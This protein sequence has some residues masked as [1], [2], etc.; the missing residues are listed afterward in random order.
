MDAQKTLVPA[1]TS[2]I[3]RELKARDSM[4][5][6]LKVFLQSSGFLSLL[7]E[8]RVLA[9]LCGGRIDYRQDAGNTICRKITLFSVGSY[10]C[11]IG[12]N[13][14]AINLVIRHVALHPL[15]RR[16]HIGQHAA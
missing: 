13:V 12:C 11:L 15:D 2:P 1:S 16:F 10:G 4:Y 6:S 8:F 3:T 7:L 9:T 5:I 14:D